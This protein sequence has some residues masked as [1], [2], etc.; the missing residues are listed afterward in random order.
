M[1]AAVFFALNQQAR[2]WELD[3]SVPSI[4]SAIES[5]LRMPLPFL[6]CAILPVFISFPVILLTRSQL[7]PIANYISISILCYLVANGAI[8]IL[9][10]SSLLVLYTVAAVHVYIRKRSAFS[11]MDLCAIFNCLHNAY[12]RYHSF[13]C[14]R[15]VLF[16]PRSHSCYE[17]FY[18]SIFLM[19]RAILHVYTWL[20]STSM[21]SK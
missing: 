7:P 1:I 6:F 16:F 2:A 14:C 10:F 19:I 20:L 21:T 13:C 11:L 18:A 17:H 15:K 8:M 9:I 4:F 5:N 3:T 12:N